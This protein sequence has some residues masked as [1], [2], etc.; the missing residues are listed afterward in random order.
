MSI[1]LKKN[2]MRYAINDSR[3]IVDSKLHWKEEV[4]VEEEV[5]VVV[6]VVV[7]KVVVELLKLL[8]HWVKL[9]ML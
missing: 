8:M 4:V 6:K 9:P 2:F 5:V 1:P 3:K 7:V